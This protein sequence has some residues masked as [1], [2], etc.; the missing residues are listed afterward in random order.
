MMLLLILGGVLLVCGIVVFIMGI[1]GCNVITKEEILG[2]GMIVVGA[3][4]MFLD[5][6]G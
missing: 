1:P 5:M 6:P 2:F 4:I 3:A